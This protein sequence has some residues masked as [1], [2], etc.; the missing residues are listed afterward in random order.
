MR[1]AVMAVWRATCNGII[2]EQHSNE[3]RDGDI[4]GYRLIE[5]AMCVCC[6]SLS[7]VC[8]LPF[9]CSA[10]CL[11]RLSSAVV[12]KGLLWIDSMQQ[13]ATRKRNNHNNHHQTY[14]HVNSIP[15]KDP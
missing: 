3:E 10:V 4:L 15:T 11:C 13:G 7:L 6:L 2:T 12:R 14:L 9:C 1:M 5:F 8:C